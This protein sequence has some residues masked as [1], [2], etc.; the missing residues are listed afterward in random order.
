MQKITL[1]NGCF[2]CT[3]AIFQTVK[4]VKSVT[5]GYMGGD[6]ANPTYEQVC[7]GKTGHAEV[8]QLE[9]D[10]DELSLDELLL[11]FFKTHDATTLNRQ[12]NDIGTQYRSAIFYHNDEQKQAAEA[13]IVKLTNEKVYDNPIV[14]E[15]TAATEFYPA[16]DYHQNYFAGNSTKSYCAFVIQ[17]KL[18]KFAKEFLDKIKPELLQ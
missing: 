10:A 2:W 17:P 3:E 5:S 1:G 8:I 14:T 13:M 4:G 7:T 9:Y 16:E 15:V 11:I 12:G 6:V 18:N